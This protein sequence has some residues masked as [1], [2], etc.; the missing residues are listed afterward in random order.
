MAAS[1]DLTALI[2][3][4]Q[5]T[6]LLVRHFERQTKR[7]LEE[8][9]RGV[10]QPGSARARDLLA[11]IR[12][13]TNT[14]DPKKDSL[15]RRWIRR[16]IPRSFV[17]GDK[18][19]TRQLQEQLRQ[20]SS[21]D[22][23]AFGQISRGFTGANTASLR[24]VV[25]AMESQL[26]RAAEDTLATLNITIRR[27][28]TTILQDKNIRQATVGGIIRGQTG[29]QLSDDIAGIILTGKAGPDAMKRLRDQGFRSDTTDL[30][31]QLSKGQFITIGKRRFNVRD[32]ANLVSRT[33]ARE[34]HKVAE[35]VRLQQNDV[36]HVRISRHVQGV[37]DE[38]TPF[39][40]KV[41]YIGSASVDPL[42]FP[43]LSSLPGGG[44]PFHPN[45]RHVLEPF[46]ADFETANA[47]DKAKESA[48]LIPRRFLGKGSGDIRQLV[49]E[50]ED[51]ELEEIAPEGFE[52]L[53]EAA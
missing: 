15:V 25:S 39:A 13:L 35:V 50:L 1:R 48:Q 38:C 6:P 5:S 37:R 36:D 40:G 20:V 44:P 24:G 47:I 51:S 19:A 4:D 27:T 45:C 18:A 31:K 41:F 29:R 2:A 53:R 46:V 26:T 12:K 23:A 22:Q 32:Y 3:T 7:I 30:Y 17:L 14:L 52:D 49:A 8:L 43:K 16:E 33:Q 10:T 21:E 11:R 28:Q 42:G 34:A 9:A